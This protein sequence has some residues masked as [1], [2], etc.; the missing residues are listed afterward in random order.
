MAGPPRQRRTVLGAV[1]TKDSISRHPAGT[2][3]VRAN[4]LEPSK[5][6]PDSAEL[7]TQ[8]LAPNAPRGA[9]GFRLGPQDRNRL[10][11]PVM[12]LAGCRDDRLSSELHLKLTHCHLQGT[13]AERHPKASD[14]PAC[15]R[16]HP[17]S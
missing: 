10:G 5:D 4:W 6:V 2:F 12:K 13:L 15:G 1:D 7:R 14:F 8:V 17:G 16:A 11:H 3:P 9:P